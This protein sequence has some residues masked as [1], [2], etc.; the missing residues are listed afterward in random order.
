MTLGISSPLSHL[1]S[2]SKDDMNEFDGRAYAALARA[3]AGIDEQE[4]LQKLIQPFQDSLAR[5]LANTAPT[6]TQIIEQHAARGMANLHRTTAEIEAVR[7][8]V[9]AQE[10]FRLPTGIPRWSASRSI[11]KS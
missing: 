2:E 8:R 9:T 10:R 6:S 5:H 7:A 11:C 3:K 4:R 1:I